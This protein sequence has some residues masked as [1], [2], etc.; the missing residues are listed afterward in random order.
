[1]GNFFGYPKMETV[2]ARSENGDRKLLDGVYRN[3]T[4]EY[5]KD[6]AWVG[7]EKI[8]GTNIGVVWD[9][10]KVSYQGHTQK[11]ELP[12]H[13]LDY[14]SSTFSTDEAEELF[15]QKFGAEEMI[16]FGEC[17]GP[18]I[19]SGG[20]YRDDISFILFDVY[21]PGTNTWLPRIAVEDIANT[22]G[23]S[24]VPIVF[25][26]TLEQGVNFI[27]THPASTFGTA[28][29]EGIVCRPMFELRE[30]NNDRIIV[31]IKWKDFKHDVWCLR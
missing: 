31:K 4:V 16:L 27:K 17:Y 24:V 13:I 29:M 26:G 22:F 23:I 18:K 8:D 20:K 1:M 2:Y 7:T 19:Q 9:G 5:L 25:V 14:L 11:S 10:D 21:C 3:K 12:K 6:L 15:E 30:R 28:Y